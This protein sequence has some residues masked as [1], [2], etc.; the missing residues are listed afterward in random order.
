M[1]TYD[2]KS[3]HKSDDSSSGLP[4]RDIFFLTLSHWPWIILSLVIC[5]GAAWLYLQY[6][7]T[8][9]T[10]SADIMI[11]DNQNGGKG[12]GSQDFGDFELFTSKTNIANEL[13]SLRSKDLMGEVV[14]RL[15]LDVEYT[16]PATFSNP[17]VYGDALP[18]KVKFNDFPAASTGSFTLKVTPAGKVTVSDMRL[19]GDKLDGTYTGKLGTGMK[20]PLGVITVTAT[21]TT[22]LKQPVDLIVTKSPVAVARTAYLSKLGVSKPDKDGTVIHL[23]MSDESP[24]RADDVLNAVIGVY[25]ENWIRDKNRIAVSTSNFI[26]ER[27]G[28]IE[29]ELGHVDN[30]I[31]TYKSQNLIPDVQAASAMYMNQSQQLG[32]DILNLSNDLKMARYIR[33]YLASD[34]SRNKLLPANT[35]IGDMDLQSGISEYNEKVLQRNSL[36]AKSSD[37]N[38]LVIAIDEQLG[39]LRNSITASVD[40]YIVGLNGQ[41]SSLRGSAARTNSQIASNPLQSKY[42]LSVERQQKVKESLYLYLLQKREENELSQAFTAYNTNIVNSP[43]ASGLAPT[44][45][46]LRILGIAA[47]AGLLIPFLVIYI[48]ELCNTRIRGR[49]DLEDV[50]IPFLGEVPMHPNASTKTKAGEKEIRTIIVEPGKR[51]VVNEAIRV[52]RTNLEFM[53]SDKKEAEIIVFT[54]LNVGSGKSFLTMNLAMALAMKNKRVLVI[55]GDM[56]HASTSAYVNY[57]KRG[58]SD[59]LSRGDKPVQEY[60]VK[61]KDD[62]TLDVLP[63]GTIPP[64]PTELLEQPRFAAMMDKLSKEYDYIF[65]DCPP[66][67]VVADT[68][69]LDQYAD[70]TVFLL[71]AG[72]FDRSLIPELERLYDEKKFR[73]MCIVLNGT[74]TGKGKYGSPYAY[75]YGYGYGSYQSYTSDK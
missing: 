10:R 50:N 24:E 74:E 9:F 27:L 45:H 35:D 21:D 44:P 8:V 49:K 64:N 37:K 1:K 39:A 31:S 30:D 41:M 70:R 48:K 20:L 43:D 59:Y 17:V 25:N 57:P 42:L 51:D 11:M 69:I 2:N 47:L 71:R 56:R 23:T 12:G 58:M 5:V 75:R 73:N 46:R 36:I 16:E 6:Q 61:P 53:R 34:A 18:V 22:G 63:V 55:D 65:I 40:N 28:V 67:E 4:M 62:V 72:L 13:N 66:I 68:Q 32:N 3:S 15:N 54:S 26:N 52:V 7:P 19:D 38:P 29:G 33:N 60:I 14:E